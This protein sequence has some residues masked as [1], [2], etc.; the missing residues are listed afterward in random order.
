[1]TVETEQLN[2]MAVLISKEAAEEYLH[3]DPFYVNGSM[4]NWAIREWVNMFA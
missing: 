3:G 4:S 2:T 1:M